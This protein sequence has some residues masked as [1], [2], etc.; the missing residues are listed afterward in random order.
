VSARALPSGPIE[1]TIDG[2]THGGEG[3]ARVEGKA[4]FVAGTIPG[5]R[6]R[7]EVVDDRKRWARADC[8]RCS[9]PARTGSPRPAPTYPT[10][11]GATSSTSPPTRSAG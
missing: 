6:I 7:L 5:E 11:A 8:W 3:V 10:A 2:F 1:A 4:V 9:T